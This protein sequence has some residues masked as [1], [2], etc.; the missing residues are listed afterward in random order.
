[1]SYVHKP[2]E[3]K[4]SKALVVFPKEMSSIKGSINE[5]KML[6]MEIK[7]L[8]DQKK[9]LVKKT[10]DLKKNIASYLQ[11]K[12]QNGVKCN[13]VAVVMVDKEKRAGKSM[14][15]RDS[16]ALRVLED[17]GVPEPQKALERIL[18]S[19]KGDKVSHYEIKLTSLEKLRKK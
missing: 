1:M 16:D 17:Y 6:N 14:K 9:A 5:L 3:T 12:D 18:E 10:E 4:R 7:R 19:R 8:N 13:D 15:E 2:L 11:N